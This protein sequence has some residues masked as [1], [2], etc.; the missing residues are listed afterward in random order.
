MACRA[1]AT[2]FIIY[3]NILFISSVSWFFYHS[4]FRFINNASHLW[5]CLYTNMQAV[6]HLVVSLFRQPKQRIQKLF[7]FVLHLLDWL[8]DCITIY[9][10]DICEVST[11]VKMRILGLWIVTSCS[12]VGSYLT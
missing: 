1:T 6:L 10:Q 7:S 3:I 12:L 11:A 4:V 2:F 9:R 5:G 8:S